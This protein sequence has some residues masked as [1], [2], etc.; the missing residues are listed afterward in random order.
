[1]PALYA[2]LGLLQQTDPQAETVATIELYG[3]ARPAA[4]DPPG[5]VPVVV[6]ELTENAGTVDETEIEIQLTT[7]ISGQ[8]TGAD[9]STGTIPIWARIKG[10]AGDWWSDASVTVEGAGGEI[11]M[12]QTGTENGDPVARLF[13]GA[14]AQL[15][16]AIFRG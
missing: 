5:G 14:T 11:E 9:A 8:I 13:N 2:S 3:T 15:S 16:S 10:P 4:G 12:P 1:M 6:M 7:P